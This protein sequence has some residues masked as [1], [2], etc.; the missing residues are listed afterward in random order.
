MSSKAEVEKQI[1]ELEKALRAADGSSYAFVSLTVGFQAK[2]PSAQMC[3]QWLEECGI[4]AEDVMSSVNRFSSTV[5]LVCFS[6][7]STPPADWLLVKGLKTHV[8]Q[9]DWWVH[10]VINERYKVWASAQD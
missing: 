5:P 1:E 2:R 4:V 10:P 7:G 3:K 6:H 8:V 9:A